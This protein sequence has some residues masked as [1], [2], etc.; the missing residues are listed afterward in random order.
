MDAKVV[1][2]TLLALRRQYIAQLESKIGELVL[3]WK[4]LADAPVRL[5]SYG[6]FQRQLH[7]LRGTAGSYGYSEVGDIAA[8]IETL[9]APSALLPRDSADKK[10]SELLQHLA[11]LVKVLAQAGAGKHRVT[12]PLRSP[13]AAEKAL[14]LLYIVDDDLEFSR[15]TVERIKSHA[16]CET[17]H[18]KTEFVAAIAKR[19]PDA[20][21][22]DMKL[23]EG[24]LAGASAAME[25]TSHHRV[26]VVFVSTR[27]DEESRL[28][29]IRAGADGYFLKQ[30]D[31]FNM[32][33]LLDHLIRA[34]PTHPYRVMLIDDDV[35]LNA[36]YRL[37]LQDAG[38]QTLV[39]ES[40]VGALE[41]LAAFMPEIILL[42]IAM[43]QINGLEFGALVRQYP[44]YNHIP[45]I[46]LSATHGE[47]LH[48][49]AMRLGGDD[50]L[51]KPLAADYLTQLLLAR[52]A[53]ARV[54]RQGEQR[55]QQA[56]SELGNIQFG[57]NKHAIVSIADL[58]GCITY[59]NEK[60][61]EVTGYTHDEVIGQNH[62]IL[63]SGLHTPEFYEALWATIACGQI[64]NGEI[65]NRRKDG[66]LYTVLST[67]IPI[68]D[69]DGLPQRYLSIRTEIT[70]I[71]QL[72][73]ELDKEHERLSLA[74]E[75]TN[76]GIWEWNLHSNQV[77]YDSNWCRLLGYVYPTQPSWPMLIHPD[78]FAQAFGKLYAMLGTD[79]P[80][81][82]SE[83]RKQNLL[84]E[85]D[86]VIESGKVVELDAEGHPLRIMG[87]I[88]LINERKKIEAQS[89]ALQE[90]LNQAVKMEAV[91]H[92]TAGIAHDFRAP[93]KIQT[94]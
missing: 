12:L 57:L 91:G 24:D 47:Q 40:A 3:Q 75:A 86:W 78:D 6:D 25:L 53:R 74:L 33:T 14:P 69:H 13:R 60:F 48:L 73:E 58:S 50:F 20:V 16:N 39:L 44:A 87:T 82:Y 45:I 64:W 84:G 22:M 28:A 51:A 68:V 94:S 83:H 89:Q 56:L 17:F 35:H 43:P 88:Q 31:S 81:Y 19:L 61:V 27:D 38:I 10:I 30:E 49:A 85:W 21:I 92:L 67:I 4:V 77:L 66:Q 42:D 23:P 8:Q 29:A 11:A 62:R 65:T 80:G 34:T 32:V 76:T 54:S 72:N 59:V 7:S 46:Y 70:R 18:S 93:L 37:Q 9:L 15:L 63:K 36:L 26:P 1:Q 55:L 79:M 41:K 52:L 71:K 5:R 90:Q 2:E